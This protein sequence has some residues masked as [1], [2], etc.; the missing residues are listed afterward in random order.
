[1]KFKLINESFKYYTD[2][3]ITI[4]V[5][6]GETA[7]DG[8]VLG[9]TFNSNPWNKGLTKETDNRVAQN[10]ES[11]S[12]GMKGL[13]PWNKGLT[14]ETN[15][16]LKATSEKI[17]ASMQGN[18][19]WNKGLNKDSD[20]RLRKSGEKQS[21]TKQENP[22]ISWNKGLTKETDDRIKRISDKLTGHSSFVL[23]WDIQK[24]KE[25]ETKKKNG[26]FNVS[27]PE[28]NLVKELKIAFGDDNIISP[29]RDARYPFNCDAYVKSEDLF[30]ELNGTW[31]HGNHPFDP[32]NDDDLKLLNVWK[33]KAKIKPQSYNWAI[34][35]WTEI[36]PLKLE[37]FRKNNL[38]FKIIYPKENLIIDK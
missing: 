24:Q 2:G 6:D 36:D 3:K 34:K 25:Y 37:T 26:T 17:S 15:D 1:M 31:Y 8:F 27:K 11:T 19:P 5:K 4:K 13:T 30:I 28:E 9:R 7:P 32:D 14:K 29:Y 12:K 21:L 16:I 38:N 20:E 22:P 33:E 10:A 35:V 23:D 18:T